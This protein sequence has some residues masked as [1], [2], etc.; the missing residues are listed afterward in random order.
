MFVPIILG[1]DKATVSVPSPILQTY[2]VTWVYAQALQILYITSTRFPFL[3]DDPTPIEQSPFIINPPATII[4]FG[5]QTPGAIATEL[6][7]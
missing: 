1:S 2:H 5:P 3:V 7:E 4:I 6:E